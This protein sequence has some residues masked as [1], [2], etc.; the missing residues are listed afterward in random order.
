MWSSGSGI[1]YIIQFRAYCVG[2]TQTNVS[3]LAMAEYR[4]RTIRRYVGQSAIAICYSIL[5]LLSMTLC[6][7]LFVL[8]NLCNQGFVLKELAAPEIGI[9]RERLKLIKSLNTFNWKHSSQ[10]VCN[11]I[12][13]LDWYRTDQNRGESLAALDRWE[14]WTQTED[15]LILRECVCL[16]Y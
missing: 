6:G 7:W 15:V 1:K 4:N 11:L 13:D 2:T 3:K 14:Y 5:L 10:S 16:A 12:K 8:H 9:A